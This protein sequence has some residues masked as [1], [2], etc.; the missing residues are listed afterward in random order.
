MPVLT[1]PTDA[2]MSFQKI[3]VNGKINLQRGVVDGEIFVHL[4]QPAG[5]PRFTYVRLDGEMVTALVIPVAAEPLDGVHCFQIGYAI[6]PAY[7][8]RGR[9]KDAVNAA[10]T[11]LWTG[12][13]RNGVPALC[14]ETIVGSDNEPSKRSLP[15]RYLARQLRC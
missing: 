1:D 4:D 13:S 5:A 14:V 9:A 12:L 3:L 8:N 7:R 2:L 11:E 6:P 10:V 15:R